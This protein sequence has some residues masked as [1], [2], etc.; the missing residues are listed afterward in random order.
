MI[1]FTDDVK[2]NKIRSLGR[3]GDEYDPEDVFQPHHRKLVHYDLYYLFLSKNKS[4]PILL[5]ANLNV[6]MEINSWF[7]QHNKIIKVFYILYINPYFFSNTIFVLIFC[8]KFVCFFK[9][10]LWFKS[11]IFLTAARN[12]LFNT[13]LINKRIARLKIVPFYAKVFQVNSH[14]QRCMT[15][16]LF[17]LC[18]QCTLCTS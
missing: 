7:I 8:L 11:G 17:L 13:F 15:P 14:T 4:V 12:K 2:M 18:V 16:D 9:R 3:V 5:E 6:G 1:Q 10:K